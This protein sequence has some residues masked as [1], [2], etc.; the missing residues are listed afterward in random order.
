MVMMRKG[1]L[2][3]ECNV[4]CSGSKAAAARRAP[5]EAAGR[6]AGVARAFRPPRAQAPIVIKDVHTLMRCVRSGAGMHS[7]CCR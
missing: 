6:A 2:S 4:W 3:E 5:P 1:V 7:L